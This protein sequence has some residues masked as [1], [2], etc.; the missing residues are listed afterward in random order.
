MSDIATKV[1]TKRGEYA[2]LISGRARNHQDQIVHCL[3]YSG[4]T[5][6]LRCPDYDWIARYTGC[7]F[8]G[9]NIWDIDRTEKLFEIE[10]TKGG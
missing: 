3:L 9:K 6:I 5:L 4:G 1:I 7:V 10:P 8:D 2:T